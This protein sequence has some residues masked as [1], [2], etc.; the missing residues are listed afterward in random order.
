MISL[1][2]PASCDAV[3]KCIMCMLLWSNIPL[4]LYRLD[5]FVVSHMYV[6]ACAVNINFFADLPGHS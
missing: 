6:Y 4:S 3:L 5:L 1:Y 2:V